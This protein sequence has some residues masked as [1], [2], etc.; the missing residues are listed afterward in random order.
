MYIICVIKALLVYFIMFFLPQRIMQF[1][2][3]LGYLI[4]NKF[5]FYFTINIHLIIVITNELPQ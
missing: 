5:L 3:K 4:N 1:V 2:D